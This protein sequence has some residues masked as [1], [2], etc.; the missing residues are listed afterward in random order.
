MNPATAPDGTFRPTHV[1]PPYGL[2]TWTAPDGAVP[3]EQLD[4][5]LPVMLLD[6]R[7]DWGR[8]QCSNG[9]AAWVDARLLVPL[10]QVPPAAGAPLARSADARHLLARVE[11]T[12]GRYR[13]ATEDLAAGRT[14]GEAFRDTTRGLRVGAVVDGEAVWLYDAAHDRWC[15]C[16]GTAMTT[17]AAREPESGTP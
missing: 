2:A 13:Q 3:S 8:A 6:R 16:D 15:Y 4:P 14:D 12:F 1:V 17:F 5:L 9:W 7:G 11:E 10:P